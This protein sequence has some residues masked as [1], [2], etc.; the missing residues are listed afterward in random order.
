M[1]FG[2]EDGE[3]CR[4][5]REGY[6]ICENA[7][8]ENRPIA[9]ITISAPAYQS[10][11]AASNFA[12]LAASLAGACPDRNVKSRCKSVALITPAFAA[13]R[14]SPS[15]YCIV[16]ILRCHATARALLDAA[17]VSC[18]R[19]RGSADEYMQT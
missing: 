14:R 9:P 7:T 16:A 18:T 17:G 10:R 15:E 4:W 5:C 3:D 2:K 19:H 11:W 8:V 12:G 6:D 13:I 1:G